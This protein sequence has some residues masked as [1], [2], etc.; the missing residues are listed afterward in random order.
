MFKVTSSGRYQFIIYKEQPM[1]PANEVKEVPIEEFGGLDINAKIDSEKNTFAVITTSTTDCFST[2][3]PD[4][5]VKWT[6]VLQE[7]LG[8]GMS[9]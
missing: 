4:E 8:K 6:R 7:Y 9:T 1:T 3:S 2:D 5:M